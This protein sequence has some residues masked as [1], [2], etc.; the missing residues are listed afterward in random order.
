MKAL[1]MTEFLKAREGVR[2][3]FEGDWLAHMGKIER[4]G[5]ILIWGAAASGKTRYAIKLCKYLSQFTDV[6]YNSYEEAGRD[7]LRQAFEEEGMAERN[8]HVQM[9]GGEPLDELEKRLSKRS[10]SVVIL[11]SLQYMR[12]TYDRYCDFVRKF[13]QKLF[14]F[15]SHAEGTQPRGT[16]A[17]SVQFDAGVKVFVQGFVAYATSRYGGGEPFII[18]PEKVKELSIESSL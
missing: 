5:T 6:L 8:G 15:I 11:D 4:G 3:P 18:S 2:F 9:L 10:P 17:V 7:S 16:T 14:V 12:I 13:P 1:S